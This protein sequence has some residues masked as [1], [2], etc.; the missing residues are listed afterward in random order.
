M[1]HSVPGMTNFVLRYRSISLG[2]MLSFLCYFFLREGLGDGER[3]Y[4]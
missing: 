3:I 1:I 4:G 2:K